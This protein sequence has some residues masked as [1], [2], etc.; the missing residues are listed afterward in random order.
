ML[1]LAAATGIKIVHLPSK[2]AGETIPMLLRGDAQLSNTN[3]S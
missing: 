2:G 1:A 3:N